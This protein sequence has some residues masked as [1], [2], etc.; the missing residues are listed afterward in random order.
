MADLQNQIIALRRQI[1]KLENTNVVFNTEPKNP[2][3]Q[4]VYVNSTTGETKYWTGKEWV[5]TSGTGGGGLTGWNTT[6]VFT[7]TDYRTIAWTSGVV[8][9]G[10][11]TSKTDYSTNSGNFTMAATTYFYWQA[12]NPTAIQTTSTA[13]DVVI[14]GGV[15][16]AVGRMNS[17]T[18]NLA[19]LKVFGGPSVDQII[20]D[21]IVANSI[22]SNMLQ[23]N[24]ITASKLATTLLYAGAITLDTNGLIKGGQTAYDAGT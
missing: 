3:S 5:I 13:G 7:A 10:T 22:T 11:T 23:A 4:T 8:S 6:V 24:S 18:A 16:I 14:A 2:N 20:A 21:E 15:L 17:D 12:D 19:S 9:I 1:D